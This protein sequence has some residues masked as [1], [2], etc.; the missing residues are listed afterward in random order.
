MIGLGLCGTCIDFTP[1]YKEYPRYSSALLTYNSSSEVNFTLRAVEWPTTYPDCTSRQNVNVSL[2][3][4]G[5]PFKSSEFYEN[6]KDYL[7]CKNSD[8]VKIDVKSLDV[9]AFRSPFNNSLAIREL[10][11]NGTFCDLY[12]SYANNVTEE[13]IHCNIV[14]NPQAGECLNTI[15]SH[16]TIFWIN[17]LLRTLWT[18]C[19]NTSFNLMDGTAMHLVNQYSGDYAW[20]TI[21]AQL[22]AM[23]GPLISG[24]VIQDSDDP[25]GNFH[26]FVKL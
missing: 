4:D 22:G 19:V 16:A 26:H 3:K 17:L 1:R 14:N 23:I 2:C 6:I 18:V 21:W 15:G 25:S 8:G 9:S 11:D 7:D 20:V 5:P 10:P 12:V 24:A 13:E